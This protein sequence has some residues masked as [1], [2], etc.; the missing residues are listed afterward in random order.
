M[1]KIC[2]SWASIIWAWATA[3]AAKPTSNWLLLKAARVYF[4]H[5]VS[6]AADN[7]QTRWVQI[8]LGSSRTF[9]TIK[10]LP[11]NLEGSF[12]SCGFPTRFRIEVSDDS[13]FATCAMYYDRNVTLDEFHEFSGQV[14]SISKQATARYVRLTAT[15]LRD[16][17]LALQKIMILNEGKDIAIGCRA[18]ESHPAPEHN[19]QA[20]TRPER[21]MGEFVVTDNPQNVIP[22]E[23]WKPVANV[24]ETPVTVS[25]GSISTDSNFH[26]L[27]FSLSLA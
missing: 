1:Q 18:S 4:A 11:D 27:S 9:D 19:V 10:L 5:Y 15:Q 12:L 23:K 20:L 8:D 13:T 16:A 22:Q 17:R 14:L 2:I 26:S 7:G 6:P 25:L 24:V 21:P 3:S